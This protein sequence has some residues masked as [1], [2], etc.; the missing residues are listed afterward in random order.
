M[1]NFRSLPPKRTGK[2]R[3]SQTKLRA[4]GALLAPALA[5]LVG[6]ASLVVPSEEARAAEYARALSPQCQELLN[7]WNGLSSFGAFAISRSGACGYSWRARNEHEAKENALINCELHTGSH[8]GSCRIFYVHDRN[9]GNYTATSE[10]SDL[11]QQYKSHRRFKAYA[12]GRRGGCGYS[13]GKPSRQAAEQTALQYCYS[14]GER[15]CRIW[16]QE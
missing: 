6:L 12:I 9:P 13:Y 10:C 5:A 16:A 4:D 7:T 11:F 14:S 8:K 3:A 2:S 15:E 1:K